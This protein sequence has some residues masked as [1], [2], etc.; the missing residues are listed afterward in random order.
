MGNA[1]DRRTAPL[2]AAGGLAVLALA[3]GLTPRV[4]ATAEPKP[5]E[6]S[7]DPFTARHTLVADL[8]PERIRHAVHRRGRDG[9][10]LVGWGKRIVELPFAPS[11][12]A[13]EVVPPRK[14]LDFSNGG[15]ALDID[16][17]GIDEVVVARPG[18]D[19]RDIEFLWYEEVADRRPWVEH[20]L[21]RFPHAGSGAPHDIVPFSARRPDGTP[22]KGVVAVIDRQQLVWYETP[23]DPRRPWT[24]H[25]IGTLPA[26]GQS[27]LLVGD[28]A[29]HGRSDLLCG[30]F[31]AECPADPSGEVWAFHRYGDWDRNGWGGMTK[32]ALVDLDGDGR[33]EVVATEAE[34]PDA[35][36]GIFK[37]TQDRTKPWQCRVVESRLYCPHSLVAADL[38]ADGRTDIV[39]GEMTCGGW[40]F[41]PAPHPRVTAYMNRGRGDIE[42]RT[43]SE[44]WGVH[45]MGWVAGGGPRG[46]FLYAADEIQDQKFKD[47]RTRVS[48]WHVVPGR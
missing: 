35:R 32:H 18:A 13:A 12:V 41:P 27:G 43:L 40:S 37:P 1:M 16:G 44:G 14:G 4:A 31:W 2:V 24:R 3:L 26:K 46:L 36:L 47:M 33:P 8:G 15:C 5:D 19:G 30:M 21:G 48:Y 17:D 11:A 22:V 7:G 34:I 42:A 23:A 45:E 10:R 29:G 39:V 6:R 20:P 28:V 25:D 9:L 38:D